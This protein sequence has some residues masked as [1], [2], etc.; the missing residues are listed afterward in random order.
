MRQQQ[1]RKPLSSDPFG[2]N[3]SR[4]QPHQAGGGIRG[5]GV[6]FGGRGGT[7]TQGVVVTKSL[8]ALLQSSLSNGVLNLSHKHL[9]EVPR[10]VFNLHEM[11]FEG[12]EWWTEADLTRL[13]LSFNEI[14]VIPDGITNLNFLTSLIL[15]N[16]KLVE[17][18]PEMFALPLE[19]VL[20]A[21]NALTVVPPELAQC[22]TIVEL[23]FSHNKLK[24]FDAQTLLIGL[25]ALLSA[26]RSSETLVSSNS[27]SAW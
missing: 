18:N 12:K 21:H 27:Y 5:R 20:V 8:H 13:D 22:A 17:M 9:T 23:D 6:A 3:S 16:N 24:S 14:Q 7:T 26:L 2:T 15:S 25:P 10:E 11:Q 19:R 4:A 1:Q